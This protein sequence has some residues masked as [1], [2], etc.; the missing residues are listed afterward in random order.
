MKIPFSQQW[1]F[2]TVWITSTGCLQAA[3]EVKGPPVLPTALNLLHGCAAA[4]EAGSQ[5]PFCIETRSYFKMR[6]VSHKA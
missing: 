4:W 6:L 1:F 5:A 3:V 2:S